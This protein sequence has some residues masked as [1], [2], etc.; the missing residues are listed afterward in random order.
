MVRIDR[1][2]SENGQNTVYK[3]S[4]MVKNDQ[5]VALKRSK[6]CSKMVKMGQKMVKWQ[7]NSQK[8]SNIGQK[9]VEF[10]F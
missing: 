9:V 6:R 4:K 1:K 7:Q 10:T 2:W 3:W 8:W 5:K